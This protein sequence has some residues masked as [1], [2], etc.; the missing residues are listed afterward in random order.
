MYKV[1]LRRVLRDPACWGRTRAAAPSSREEEGGGRR[2]GREG[3]VGMRR[4]G[5]APTSSARAV[6][7]ASRT[8]AK[9]G[10]IATLRGAPSALLCEWDPPRPCSAGVAAAAAVSC[11]PALALLRVLSPTAAE[12]TDRAVARRRGSEPGESAD[13]AQPARHPR[14]TPSGAAGELRPLGR[15]GPAP[16][17]PTALQGCCGHCSMEESLAHLSLRVSVALDW[18]THIGYIGSQISRLFYAECC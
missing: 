2:S 12:E 1:C 17:A 9:P 14:E 18:V 16:P 10:S 8:S 7:A 3:V 4:E 6:Q 11:G 15:E 5:A 13:P